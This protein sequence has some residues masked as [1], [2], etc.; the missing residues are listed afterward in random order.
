MNVKAD[1]LLIAYYF[2]PLGMGGVGRPLALYR[3]LPQYGYRTHVLTVKN[4]AYPQYDY[5]LLDG[6]DTSRVHRAGSYDPSRLLYL[7]GKRKVKNRP[8]GRNASRWFFPDSKTGWIKPALRAARNIIERE[9]IKAV[10]TTSPPPSVHGI[11]WRLRQEYYFPWVAD[12]RDLWFSRP[13]EMVYDSEYKYI[14]AAIMKNDIVRYANGVIVVNESIQSYLG[15]G[16]VIHNAADDDLVPLWRTKHNRDD[17]QFVIGVLG[18]LNELCPLEPLLKGIKVL[19]QS[20]STLLERMRIRH[21]GYGNAEELRAQAMPSGLEAVL[22]LRGYQPRRAAIEML[23]D[24]NMLYLGVAKQ[25]KYHIVPGRLF[26][27]LV[28]GKPILGMVAPDSETARLIVQSGRGTAVA[29]DDGNGAAEYIRRCMNDSDYKI[30]NPSP[31]VSE[32][33]A[34]RLTEKYARVLDNVLE[35]TD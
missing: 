17:G 23:A 4:I 3:Y 16:T 28:S 13:I 32:F 2:P 1:I 6:V 7:L 30:D 22:D 8:G 35:R 29:L 26:D 5:T 31:D 12:F 9:D 18:T 20:N 24:V 34:S 27:C 19:V 15:R 10:I 11:G 14:N 21:V 25:G 33:L